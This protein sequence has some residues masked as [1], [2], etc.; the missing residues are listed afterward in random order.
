MEDAVNGA[1]SLLKL[2]PWIFE[3]EILSLLIVLCEFCLCGEKPWDINLSERTLYWDGIVEFHHHVLFLRVKSIDCRSVLILG[4]VNKTAAGLMLWVCIHSV[5]GNTLPI[6]ASTKYEWC[7]TEW[8]FNMM[9]ENKSFSISVLMMCHEILDG[10]L[11]SSVLCFCIQ[12]TR[13]INMT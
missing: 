9:Q 12:H 8:V 2:L 11:L 1:F 4:L 3:G 5:L 10:E 7:Y 6:C 13:H